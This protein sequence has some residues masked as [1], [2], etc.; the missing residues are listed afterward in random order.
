MK[1]YIVDVFA[2]QKYQ[3]NQLAVFL[4][5]SD[6]PTEEMQKIAREINYSETTFI[7]SGKCENG[8]YKV[9]YF[10]PDVEIPFAGHPTLGTAF[11]IRQML[12]EG[13]S[14]K[15]V[16]NLPVGPIPVTFN[17][18]VLTM[19]QNAP[20]FGL[21]MDKPGIVADILKIG[22]EDIDG[23]TPIQVVSTGLPSLIV[24][25]KSLDAIERCAV[26]H[27]RYQQFID[28]VE[29]CNLLVFAPESEGV[30]RV[31]VFVD[32]PGF[33]EDPATGSANGNLAGYMLKYNCFG[34]SKIKYNVNQ[35]AQIGRPS[36][37]RVDAEKSEE[38]YMIKVGGKVFLI[39]EGNWI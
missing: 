4:P 7:V 10:T 3:G 9:R 37:L 17:A 31:R 22:A 32:D 38:T 15:I 6:V 23:K 14:D 21:I 19:E 1:F 34:S 36:L 2:E 5:D 29:K 25:L 28:N 12:E 26:D 39:A 33:V 35:G 16:L 24:P 18:D 13:K 11:I 20:E 27:F 30:V 8:G